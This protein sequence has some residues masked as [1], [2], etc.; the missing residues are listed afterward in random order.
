[1]NTENQNNDLEQM[2]EAF[3]ILNKKVS[4]QQILTERLID[5]VTMKNVSIVRRLYIVEL[6]CAL[7][8]AT[9]G[10]WTFYELGFSTQF[11]VA[12]VV[13]MLF[14]AGATLFVGKDIFANTMQD[15]SML[16]TMQKALRAKR[17][18]Q[19]WLYIGIPMGLLWMLWVCLEAY[20]MGE[21]PIVYGICFGGALGAVLGF[22]NYK[23][24]I[25]AYNDIVENIRDLESTE[26]DSVKKM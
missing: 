16:E 22:R 3:A 13:F 4:K 21:M 8:V 7:Y 25:G 2:R 12:T 1:M 14:C 23:R 9:V 20:G 18:E 6:I 26:E 24:T 5:K 17:L 19:Q 10:T 15:G 11:L